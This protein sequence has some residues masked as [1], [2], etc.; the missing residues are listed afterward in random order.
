MFPFVYGFTWSTGPL[1]FLGIFFA[2]V[3]TVAVVFLRALVRSKRDFDAGTSE[4]ILWHQEFHDLAPSLRRCRHE[5]AGE[6][7]C[8]ECPNGFDCRRCDVHAGFLARAS[9]DRPAAETV[10]GFRMPARYLY[11]R[12]HTWVERGDDGVMTIGLDDFASRVIGREA[13]MDLPAPGTKLR[14]FGTAWSIEGPRARVRVLSPVEGEVVATGSVEEGW[15]LKVRGPADEANL[16]H[17]LRGTEIAPWL[18]HEADRLQM[19]LAP[20]AA[21]AVLADGGEPVED[22]PKSAPDGPWPDILGDVFLM[23]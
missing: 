16:R 18:T 7:A 11:H 20:I 21:G 2:V 23:V 15:I 5:L 22:F 19:R 12:G 6:L 9:A 3:I 1:V 17:L 14:A 13:K 8:R 10:N 4:A